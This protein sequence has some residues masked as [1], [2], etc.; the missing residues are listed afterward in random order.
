MQTTNY[1]LR[2]WIASVDH[3]DYLQHSSK[4]GGT[5]FSDLSG[6]CIGT[7]ICW[8]PSKGP[9]SPDHTCWLVVSQLRYTLDS[10]LSICICNYIRR[11]ELQHLSDSLHPKSFQ[12]LHLGCPSVDE[13]LGSRNEILGQLWIHLFRPLLFQQCPFLIF[14]QTTNPA[15]VTLW[16]IPKKGASTG[17]MCLCGVGKGK[18]LISSIFGDLSGC[19]AS[20]TVSWI[21][22]KGPTRSTKPAMHLVW[23]SYSLNYCFK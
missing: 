17:L 18:D 9:T 1:I 14:I 21:P 22:A 8:I 16:I 6:F 13:K 12:L 2:I 20:V 4:M 23:C 10:A 7:T 3:L 15:D 11:G 5:I 19:C